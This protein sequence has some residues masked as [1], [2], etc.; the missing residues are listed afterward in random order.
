MKTLFTAISIVFI[1][2]VIS[3]SQ[4]SND[5]NINLQIC[6]AAGEQ[7]LPKISNLSNGDTY[8]CWFDS[9]SGS[10][11]VYL[12]RLNSQGVKQFASEGLLI[13]GNPQS[14]SLV[15]YDMITDDS[16]NAVIAFTDTR[17]GPNINPFVY[18]ISPQGNFLW[19]ANGINLANDINTFQANPRLAKT[20]DNSIVVTWI[21]SSSPN[22][23]AFQKI[24]SGGVKL[25]G[26]D[27][28]YLAGAGTENF[29]YPSVVTSDA[30]S[31]IALW[32][33]YS[34]SF[35]NPQ[36]YKL[37]TQK[38]SEAGASV[39]KDTVYNLGRVTGFFVPKIFSDA[40][41]G[42]M[43]VWQDD[44]NSTNT[45]SS[46]VQHYTS[47]GARLFPVNGS[48]GSTEAGYN[49]FDAW[50][51]YMTPANET[52]L[53]WKETN[54]LQSQF[55]IYG[56]RFSQNGT[57]LWTDNAKQFIPFGQN[58]FINQICNIKD[59]NIV[60]AF[61]EGVFG[62]ANNLQKAFST[63]KSGVTG[64]NGIIKNVSSATSAKSKVVA[65]M[66]NSGETKIVWNDD[67]NGAADIYAQNIS[68]N[69]Q[70]GNTG[71][72]AGNNSQAVKFS[73]SQNYPNPF[74][75]GTKINYELSASGGGNFISLKVYDI[76]GNEIATL[77]NQKQN[78]GSYS[79][80][81]DGRNLSS[82]IYFYTFET[83]DFKE[84]RSM[85]LIK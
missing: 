67:R 23:I 42:A 43:Y 49:K 72:F 47:S 83:N 77:V 53:F 45:Q 71:T 40:S 41:N 68:I 7:A 16:D 34:G 60:V 46:F 66:S 44:R 82:G 21:Y 76:L 11:A 12:Q 32:S 1:F 54:S 38:F 79:V 14:T 29:T 25:W 61:N 62:S 74:N 37:Y 9:R 56:Q 5:P 28:I 31:V 13:S 15:D 2:N 17:S 6:G 48:E 63:G 78:A 22:K 10:Y 75:P 24:S 50:A 26:A 39:W 59:T 18:K 33:G 27:P 81:F 4:W 57:R 35:L 64:W 19:G 3:Y 65:V 30:G 36:N 84:T 58:S 70:L 8:I 55:A 80:D 51:A 69:G 85:L 52:Y 20:T 73:L